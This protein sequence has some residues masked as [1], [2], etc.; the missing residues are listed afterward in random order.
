MVEAARSRDL[1]LELVVAS[2]VR[3]RLKD[4][5][6]QNQSG[7]EPLC[8]SSDPHPQ[9]KAIACPNRRRRRPARRRLLRWSRLGLGFRDDHRDASVVIYPRGML[10]KVL[11]CKE[12]MS[13]CPPS[14][15]VSKVLCPR[16]LAHIS[17]S[18]SSRGAIHM[19]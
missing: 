6:L 14:R 18:F 11:I 10:R 16:V 17:C 15:S 3:E 2:L 8:I 13:I 7:S 19:V 12:N 1:P 4:S 9:R 5:D